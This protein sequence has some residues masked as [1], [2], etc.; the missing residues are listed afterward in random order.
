M[1]KAYFE[2]VKSDLQLLAD[3]DKQRSEWIGPFDR[4]YRMT[5]TETYM[6]V[7]EDTLCEPFLDDWKDYGLPIENVNEMREIRSLMED[8][9][10]DYGIM[11]DKVARQ[12]I[13]DPR[14]DRIRK[15]QQVCSKKLKN[16]HRLRSNSIAC[17]DCS[18]KLCHALKADWRLFQSCQA[19]PVI[20]LSSGTWQLTNRL[21]SRLSLGS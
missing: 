20:C 2:E 7:V 4:K 11:D 10:E 13:D 21:Y 9:G 16:F 17:Q 15:L 3:Y 14:F 5:W 19:R 12:V 8:L 6:T 18:P 1:Y